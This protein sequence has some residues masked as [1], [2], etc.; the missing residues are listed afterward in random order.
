QPVVVVEV[1]EVEE[2]NRLTGNGA[3]RTRVLHFEATDEETVRLTIGEDERSFRQAQDLSER[4][5][6]GFGPNTL[7]DSSQLSPAASCKDDL[8]VVRPL[9]SGRTGCDLRPK[10]HFVAEVFEPP[11]PDFLD[12]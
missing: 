1:L 6:E 3:V 7:V 2:L 11:Q 5:F 12:L 4:L 8:G 10:A 9:C